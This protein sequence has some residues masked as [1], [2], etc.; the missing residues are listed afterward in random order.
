M[1][2]KSVE[3][4]IPLFLLLAPGVAAA[5]KLDDFKDAASRSGCEAVPYSSPLERRCSACSATSN[6]RSRTSGIRR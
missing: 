1:Q 4:V 5:D 6:P 2:P 3:F